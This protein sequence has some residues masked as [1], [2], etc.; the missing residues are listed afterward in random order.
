MAGQLKDIRVE[1]ETGTIKGE[2]S[3]N[4]MEFNFEP[5]N[6]IS[7]GKETFYRISVWIEK[8]T[9]KI[10]IDLKWL[11]KPCHQ[12][13]GTFRGVIK[14]DT[15]FE[16]ARLSEPTYINGGKNIGKSNETNCLT[17]AFKDAFSMH[18]KQADKTILSAVSDATASTDEP[19]ASTAVSR[20]TCP[21]P[22][23]LH[24]YGKQKQDKWTAA[25]FA[26]GV[27]VQR[28]YDGNR[29]VACNLN[30]NIVIYS[31]DSK[32]YTGL[33]V[34][35][36]ELKA[37]Y[38]DSEFIDLIAA[39][40]QLYLDG[41]AYAHGLPL[42]KIGSLMR[43]KQSRDTSALEYRIYD[44]FVMGNAAMISSDRQKLLADI[45]AII[46]RLHL[47]HLKPV[48]NF[49]ISSEAELVELHDKFVTDGY[50]GAI[51]RK[52]SGVYEF[53]INGHRT[54][55]VLKYKKTQDAEFEIIDYDQGQGK[56]LGAVIWRCKVA[57]ITFSVVPNQKL[58]ERKKIYTYLEAN[59]ADFEILRGAQYTV[60]YADL[61][62][63]TGLPQQP[64]GKSFR[65]EAAEI[66]MS[67]ILG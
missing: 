63:T 58:D 53:S 62:E 8:D 39:P 15:G 47:T 49:P 13:D 40:D 32:L 57:D 25:I 33:T 60:Q 16:V 64:K 4:N 50:E 5:I 1:I 2:F 7:R 3:K 56:D 55:D 66:L 48:E 36:T 9:V 41:E 67:K 23:I 38:T 17:Q 61:N 19:A 34:L 42:N 51:I 10:P 14:V 43:S 30:N 24:P 12:F 37:L 29:M 46:E 54:H 11:S 6:Y 59:P 20:V 18:K 45:F 35:E 22:M 26:Q 31:R 52:N 44:L 21:P 28:K 27:I 65:N